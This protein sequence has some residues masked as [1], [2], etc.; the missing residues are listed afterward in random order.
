MTLQLR[1]RLYLWLFASTK[2]LNNDF[3][4]LLMVLPRTL[5]YHLR[6]YLC[7]YT[8]HNELTYDFTPA[9]TT[10]PTTLCLQTRLCTSRMTLPTTLCL[11]LR[12][13]LR[14]ND[15]T[16]NPGNHIISSLRNL[17]ATL[18]LQIR[19]FTFTYNLTHDFHVFTHYLTYD[20]TISP[21]WHRRLY[22]FSNDFTY[23]VTCSP[24]AL[25]MTF[26]LRKRLYLRLRAPTMDLDNEY[27]SS[28]MTLRSTLQYH[29]RLYDF[30]YDFTYDLTAQ[31]HKFVYI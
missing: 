8:F 17:S 29:L 22:K 9:H 27:T 23:N 11:H 20:I 30:I 2:D 19:L 31:P 14:H 3:T 26:R 10:L 1:N 25:A 12:V 4:C 18:R 5:Q 7:L 28:R 24:T 6:L 15:F 16:Y 13:Y 21:E